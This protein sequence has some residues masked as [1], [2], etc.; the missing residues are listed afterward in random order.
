MDKL[1]N[2]IK[3]NID[4]SEESIQEILS[5]FE[6]R[7]L[8]K[9]RF[10]LRNGHHLNHYFFVNSGGMR[11]YL[12]QGDKDITAWLSFENDFIADLECLTTGNP[13]RYNIQAIEN[14][15]LLAIKATEMDKLY[16]KHPEWQEFGRKLWER[17]FLEVLEG[18]VNYQTMS[19]EERYLHFMQQSDA[20]QRLPLKQISTFLGI[21]PTSL[22]RLRKKIR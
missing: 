22:S 4:I 5:H 11:I 10:L 1:E 13:S 20:L 12:N 18:M 6:K 21:T 16:K 2:F 9:D 14:T 15:E 3:S 8:K 17:A 19:A 7:I